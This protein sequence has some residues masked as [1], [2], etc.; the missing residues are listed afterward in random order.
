MGSQTNVAPNVIIMD[1]DFHIPWP[2]EER[3]NYPGASGMTM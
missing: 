2:P 3:N 1:S